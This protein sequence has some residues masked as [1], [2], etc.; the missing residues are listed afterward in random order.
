MKSIAGNACF[1]DAEM[2]K[3]VSH[4]SASYLRV[5]AGVALSS[6]WITSKRLMTF[7]FLRCV[8]DTSVSV[9]VEAALPSL[10]YADDTVSQLGI[11]S[12]ILICRFNLEVT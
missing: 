6:A 3:C 7:Y 4:L 11:F 10:V 2:T 1:E 5:D 9:Y 8:Y 12:T